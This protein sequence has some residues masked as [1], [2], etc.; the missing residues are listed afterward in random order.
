MKYVR[1]TDLDNR[2]L[3]GAARKRERLRQHRAALVAAGLTVRGTQRRRQLWPQLRGLD[4][5][6]AHRIQVNTYYR[7]NI[8]AGLSARGTPRIYGR[9][10]QREAA[11]R[12]FR[13][14]ISIP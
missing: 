6:T 9:L 4:R 8:E 11:W 2:H 14:A 3:H 13:A 5:R 1:H 10:T 7:R 12:A